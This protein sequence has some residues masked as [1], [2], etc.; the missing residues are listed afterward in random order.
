LVR[1]IPNL[2]SL[3]RLALVP[4]ALYALWNRDYGQ[5]LLWCSI[6]GVSDALDGFLARRLKA[7]S[8]AGAYLDPLGDKFLLSGSF[9]V[10][11]CNHVI[12]WW[13]AAIV[14]GRDMLMLLAIAWAFLFT[15]LRSFPPTV[16]GKLSTIIQVIAILWI[17]VGGVIHFGAA[18][19]TIQT[20]LI[21]ATAAATAW[22]A[23]HYFGHG[24]N[25]VRRDRSAENRDLSSP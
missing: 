13:L 6:A 25:M 16:W 20:A 24:I 18:G 4:I 11:A 23:I 5:A 12:P 7:T 9:L 14:V 10:L 19:D 17:L 1:Q 2:L 3:L 8:R 22:S 21:W 15:R